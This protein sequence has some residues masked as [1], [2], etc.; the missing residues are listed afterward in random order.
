MSRFR[1]LNSGQN[2]QHRAAH[3]RYIREVECRPVPASNVKI[4]KI[5]YVPTHSTVKTIA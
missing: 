5:H 1:L 4:Q 3:N 2:H